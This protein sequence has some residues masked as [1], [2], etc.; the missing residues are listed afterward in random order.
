MSTAV[1]FVSQAG[2]NACFVIINQAGEWYNTDTSGFE[3]YDEGNIADY[4]N[5]SSQTGST[6]IYRGTFP[7]LA[8]GLYDVV[9][10]EMDD[11][12]LATSDFPDGVVAGSAVYWD[13]TNLI[14]QT[15]DSFSR[16]G[17]PAGASL[18]AD[19]AGVPAATLDSANGVET[20][21]T[22][23]QA[24]RG[25]LA[26]LA[27]KLAGAGTTEVAIRNAI[28]TKA[29]ITATVDA[30]GNRTDVTLDLD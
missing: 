2:G 5:A 7:G 15:G 12:T 20:G 4:A 28:D 23:R 6:G 14:F 19:V 17:E 8:A 24:L 16:L 25:I 3:E 11:S 22:L 18:A 13:G 9:A 30:S 1:K 21:I 29:R 26:A 27:G 10:V